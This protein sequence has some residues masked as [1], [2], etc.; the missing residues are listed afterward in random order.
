MG[1]MSTKHLSH[2]MVFL[3]LTVINYI[4]EN[5]Q[6]LTFKQL[7]LFHSSKPGKRI[8]SDGALLFPIKIKICQ[9]FR[10]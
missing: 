8:I 5:G 3:Y 9:I 2:L 4:T 7:K 1:K 6:E 10:K